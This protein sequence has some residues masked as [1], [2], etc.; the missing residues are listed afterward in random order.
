MSAI[1]NVP[2]ALVDCGCETTVYTD[3]SGVEIH[4]CP[5]H[6]AAPELLAELK[7]AARGLRNLAEMVLR[8]APNYRD[9]AIKIAERQEAVIAKAEGRS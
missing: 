8:G 4:Y 3:G 1:R 9:E 2:R 7:D 5:M 6:D